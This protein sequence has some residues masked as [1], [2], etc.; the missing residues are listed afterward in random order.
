M[1]TG[2]K[3]QVKG[4]EARNYRGSRDRRLEEVSVDIRKEGKW[5]MDKRKE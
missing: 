2:K 5:R 1:L 4:K 3:K